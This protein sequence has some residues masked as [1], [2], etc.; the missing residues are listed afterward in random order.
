MQ[1]VKRAIAAIAFVFAVTLPSEDLRA[2][3]TRTDSAA[4][5]LETA[6][7]LR[8]EGHN[9]LARQLMIYITGRYGDTPAARVALE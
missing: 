6:R 4:V 9:I 7:N 1:L 5:L 2:Q 3:V 8:A